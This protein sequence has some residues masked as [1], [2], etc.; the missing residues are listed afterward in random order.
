MRFE[1]EGIDELIQQLERTGSNMSDSKAD[2]LE[3]GAEV[4]QKATQERAPVRAVNGGTLKANIE[5]SDIDG[6]DIYVFVDQ[7]GIA[8]YGYFQEFGTSNMTAQPFMAPAFN[9]SRSQI[10]QAMAMSLRRRLGL[11]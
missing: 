11:S 4:L 8:Y 3:A 5:I 6:E 10:E 9:H 2:A 7:Q 1:F